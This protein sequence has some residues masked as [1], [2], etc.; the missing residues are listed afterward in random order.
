MCL[1]IATFCKKKKKTNKQVRREHFWALGAES[2]A[3]VVATLRVRVRKEVNESA[4]LAEVSA[5]CAPHVAHLS[6]QIEKD[7]L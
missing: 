4:V 2:G 7:F 6:I 3:A 5:L 1:E